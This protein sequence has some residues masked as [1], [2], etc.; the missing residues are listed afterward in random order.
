MTR[1]GR[2]KGTFVHDILLNTGS[3]VW[4]ELVP[5]DKMIKGEVPIR[6]AHGDVHIYHWRR[7]RL[8]SGALHLQLKQV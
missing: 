5:G 3:L 7:L 2:V 1:V 8:R 4:K 6:C